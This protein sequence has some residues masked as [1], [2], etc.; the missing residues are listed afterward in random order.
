MAGKAVP[1]HERVE[2]GSFPVP[3]AEF[4]ISSIEDVV[5]ADAN[6]VAIEWAA[7]FSA[8]VS[9][10]DYIQLGNLFLGE[11]YWR[12]HLGISWDFHTLKGPE[13]IINFFKTRKEG[14]RLKSLSIDNTNATRKPT[15]TTIDYY[16]KI[17]AVQAFVT[18]DTDVGNGLGVVRL[19][20]DGTQWKAYTLYTSIRSLKGFE[21][22]T[23][24]RRPEGVEHGGKP[25]RLNWKDRRNIHQEFKKTEP[26][27]LIIGMDVKRLVFRL[28]SPGV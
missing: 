28:Q 15:K 25:G 1:S 26:A 24:P 8:A 6:Q 21:E 7:S 11:S 17:P 19:V 5:H 14:C 3:T 18:T 2:Q 4:P 27:V 10:Q 16:G 12:D 13:Q 23:G 22:P 20:K 9:S